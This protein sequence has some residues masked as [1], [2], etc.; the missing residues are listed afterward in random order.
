MNSQRQAFYARRRAAMEQDPHAEILDMA[1]GAIVA[2]LDAHWA[3]K[4]DVGEEGMTSLAKAFT[5]Q[6]GI[7]FDATAPPFRH[8]D[9]I[10]DD[11]QAV[12]TAVLDRV[13]AMLEEKKKACDALAEQYAAD[14]YPG[15]SEC[16]RQILLQILDTQWKDHLH[17]MDGLRAGINMRAY[18]QR[19]PKLEYQREG[20][21]LFEEMNARIDAQALELVFKFSLPPPPDQVRAVP[22]PM[23]A[24]A[25]APA[26]RPAA[27]G[28]ASGAGR[29]PSKVGKVGRN[30]PCPCGSG[31]KYKK[32]H[33]AA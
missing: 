24:A 21:G 33:G 2:L 23:R 9:G 14:G 3:E 8:G 4:G 28:T 22:P 16:E 1:E 30:D 32:C 20:F 27:V 13:T 26:P 31:K 29:I 7:E 5:A 17:S 6:F 19:D 25:P 12:G 10:A 11:R 15:F 18:G